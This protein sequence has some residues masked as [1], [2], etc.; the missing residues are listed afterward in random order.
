[1]MDTILNLGLNDEVVEVIATLTNNRRFALDSYRRFIQ[2]FSDVVMGISKTLHED[3][4]ENLKRARGVKY[5]YEISAEDLESLVST[6]KCI[7]KKEIGETFPN[8]V[9]VQ[10]LLAVKAAF[11]SWRNPRAVYYR[12]INDILASWGTAVNIQSMV[13]GNMGDDCGIGVAFTRNPT[14]G[15]N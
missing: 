9:K 10:F 6:F 13:F 2:M 5:D 15:E 1:M 14:T 12:R 11:S 3:V 8:D 4:L 7:Y